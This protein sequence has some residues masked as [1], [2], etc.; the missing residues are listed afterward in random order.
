VVTLLVGLV[1]GIVLGTLSAIAA[2]DDAGRRDAAADQAADAAQTATATQPPTQAAASPT[3]APAPAPPASPDKF[4][5]AYAGQVDDRTA[6]VAIAIRDGGAIAYLCD[7]KRLEAWL[8]GTAL[9]GKLNLTGPGNASLTGTYDKNSVTGL[10]TAGGRTWTLKIRVAK[11]PSGLYRST[12]QVRGA[13][14]VTGWIMLSD[15]QQVGMSNAD[16]VETPAPFLDVANRTA[17]INGVQVTAM[18]ID[19]TSTNGFPR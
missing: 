16:G 8:L 10:V 9:G 2:S 11:K 7:G 1:M 4:R 14:I 12:A 18:E 6:S 13:R 19:G 3:A 5:A 15:G 17:A